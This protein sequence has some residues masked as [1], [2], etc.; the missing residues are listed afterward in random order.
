MKTNYFIIPL[1]TILTAVIGSWLTNIQSVWYNS[2][3]FPWF[4]PPGWVIGLAWTI[5]FIL[6]MISALIVWQQEKK[7]KLLFFIGL[8]FVFNAVLNIFWSW[9]FFNQHLIAPA[10]IEAACLGV[11][12]VLLIALIAPISRLAAWLLAPYA[13]WVAFATYLTYSIWLLNF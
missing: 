13:F 11:S 4:T 1:I 2:L 7:S 6:T 10:I 12:V 5:I 9:L 8:I 3:S